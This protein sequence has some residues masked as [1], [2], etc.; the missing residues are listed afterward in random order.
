MARED[1]GDEMGSGEQLA[2][3]PEE[4]QRRARFQQ[5]AEQGPDQL[6]AVVEAQIMGLAEEFEARTDRVVRS[7]LEG[8]TA[9]GAPPAGFV[10]GAAF[11]ALLFFVSL[12]AS[13]FAVRKSRD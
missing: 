7:L 5:A 10:R 12:V 8:D 11:G 6:A 2:P 1:G 4:D 13:L 9:T 3:D